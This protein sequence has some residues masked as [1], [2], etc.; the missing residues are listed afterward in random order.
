MKDN[1]MAGDAVGTYSQD[2]AHI[3][4]A[5]GDLTIAVSEIKELLRPED[6]DVCEHGNSLNSN[7]S[8]CDNEYPWHFPNVTT[9]VD[10]HEEEG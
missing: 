8:D 5:I 2:L 7:C 3:K 10:Y 6:E 1:Y 4:S 9:T